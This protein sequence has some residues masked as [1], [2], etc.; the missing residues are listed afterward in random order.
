MMNKAQKGVATFLGFAM[1]A[2]LVIPG[3]VTGAIGKGLGKLEGILT[4]ARERDSVRSE[5]SDEAWP[6]EMSGAN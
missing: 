3:S 4:R 2:E 1:I 5:E 6:S